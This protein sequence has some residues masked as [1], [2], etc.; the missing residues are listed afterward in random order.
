METQITQQCN[1]HCDGCGNYTNYALKDE[2]SFEESKEYFRLWAH[3][4]VPN[5]FRILGGEPTIHKDLPRFVSLFFEVWPGSQRQVVTNGAFLDR[6][7]TLPDILKATDTSI[8]LSF[9]SNDPKYLDWVR[10]RIATLKGWIQRGV[11]VEF[12]DSRE[13]HRQYRGVGRFML[14][15]A[16][17]NARQSWQICPEK[18][19]RTIWR[20]RLWKCPSIM[21][22]P[23]ILSKFDLLGAPDWASYLTYEGVG[24]DANDGQLHQF[25]SRGPETA[26]GMCPATRQPYRKDIH[27]LDWNRRDARVE[28]QGP[29]LNLAAFI[30]DIAPLP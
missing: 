13:F 15:F 5:Q 11:K 12:K 3:R 20:G 6:H 9:H 7:P 22:L 1:L 27:N 18:S 2:T 21:A 10:P 29:D 26:C 24:L 14:P 19:C 4:V 28:W 30:N 25:L 23:T 8:Q 17:G 16:D